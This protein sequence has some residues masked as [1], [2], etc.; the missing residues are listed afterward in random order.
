MRHRINIILKLAVLLVT[1]CFPICEVG[2]AG[3]TWQSSHLIVP[4]IRV[5]A[6]IPRT[7]EFE[8]QKIYG[9]K[10]VRGAEVDIG[11]GEHVPGT[12]IYPDNP[13]KTI[14][15]IW[16][17]AHEKRRPKEVRLTGEKSVWR[18]HQSISLGTRLMELERI[19]GR[20]FVL[21]GFSYDLAGTVVSWEGGKLEKQFDK[22][23]RVILRL[24]YSYKS[25]YG[26]SEK[27]LNSVDG[28]QFFSSNNRVMQKINPKV[29]QIIVE[30]PED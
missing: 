19:N 22:R 10:N 28:D 14:K 11:E 9:R 24:D 29:Y 12:V 25:I 13:T 21:T 23:G 16:K 20:P 8:L 6:I 27:E 15:V 4:K 26:L 1:C 3:S 5:G 30:F 2:A 17:D 7:S 18:T